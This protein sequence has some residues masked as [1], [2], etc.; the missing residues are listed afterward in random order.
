TPFKGDQAV[1][2][3]GLQGVNPHGYSAQGFPTMNIAGYATLRTQPGG[4]VQNDH[5]W[6]YADTVTWSRGRHVFKFGGEY[7]PQSR[8]VG[9]IPEGTYGNF[10]FNGSLAGYGYADFLLG[11]PFTSTRLDPLTQRTLLDSELGL[12]ITDSFKVSSRLTLD[13]GLRWDRFGSPSYDDG[14]QYN[15]DPVTGNVI[16]PSNLVSRVSPLYPKT[17]TIAGGSVAQHPGLRNFVP[18]IGVAYRLSD[19][20][21]IRGGYGIFNETLGRYSRLSS[22][23]FQV[24]ETYQ[25]VI[26]GGQPL[27]SFPNPFPSSLAAALIPSQSVTGYPLDS[28]NGKLHQYN[29]TIERQF[30]DTGFRISYVGSHDYG[31]NYAISV[32][33]PQASLTPFTAA[34]RPYSQ[35]I[36]ASY[37]RSDGESKFN[38]M[39]FEVVRKVGQVTL[40][41]HWTLASSYSNFQ[42]G[43][44]LENPYGPL[45][46]GRDQYTP[47]QRAVFN[48]VWEIPFGKGRRYMSNAPR[49]VDG[50]LGGWQIYWLGYLESG[51]FFSPSFSGLD[52]SNTNTFGGFPDRVCNGNLAS[53]SRSVN[54]WFDPTCF[55]TPAP[56]HFGDSG[57]YVLEGPGYNMQHMS[58]AKTFNLTERFKFTFTTAFSNLFNH[59]NFVAPASNI[60][61]PG[62]VGVVSGLRDGSPARQ[63]EL[64]GRVDF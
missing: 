25:N 60:S 41:S 19:K 61:V 9:N 30:K 2:K 53:S 37:Y 21:V 48:V 4:E 23:P 34:R 8:F 62:S 17:I 32:N 35:Y 54:H 47:R 49:A 1:Q 13:L 24:T 43:A 11:Y 16:V 12:F 22:A 31:M 10:T 26:T 63:I 57:A 38:A 55:A 51:H 50:V 28:S 3:I 29:L 59:P 20:M 42:S 7:K 36:G 64:R 56:G 15:W 39:T 33:K 27:L 45:F 46:F 40:D 18:R 14:L 52:P 5:D 44:D 6:G 58:V